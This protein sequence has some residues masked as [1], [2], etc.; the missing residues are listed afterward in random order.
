M[1]LYE[2]VFSATGRTQRVTD[3]VSSVFE[4]EKTKLDLS[5]QDFK[6]R[7]YDI[8]QDS[9]CIVAVPVYNGRVPTS[10]VNNL[11]NIKGNGAIS[12]ENPTYTDKSKCITCMRCVSECPKK[13]RSL[14]P[15]LLSIVSSVAKSQFKGRKE[16]TLFL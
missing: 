1:K 15:V 2:I 14:S 5:T 9:F 7:L 13:A 4:G 3:I 12:F 16:N 11:K 6:D 8:P 10:A